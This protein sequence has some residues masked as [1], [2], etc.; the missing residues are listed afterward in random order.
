M[1]GVAL[2]HH[3]VQGVFLAICIGIDVFE[4]QRQQQ[5]RALQHGCPCP[6]TALAQAQSGNWATVL[7][8]FVF[9]NETKQNETKRTKPK[10]KEEKKRNETK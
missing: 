4:N 2:K 9:F 6:D 3:K 10:K 1:H 5:T 7:F 8:R